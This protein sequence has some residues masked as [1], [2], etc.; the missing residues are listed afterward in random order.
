M[1][2]GTERVDNNPL[3][4]WATTW[5][6]TVSLL[7]CLVLVGETHAR[8]IDPNELEHL[9]A[10]HMVWTGAVPYRDFFEPVLGVRCG[11]QGAVA[12]TTGDDRLRDGHVVSDSAAGSMP[13]GPPRTARHAW[14]IV[15]CGDRRKNN[16]RFFTTDHFRRRRCQEII[17]EGSQHL[18]RNGA[19]TPAGV[20][21]SLLLF[22]G[23]ASCLST[24][25]STP[26][27]EL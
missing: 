6:L 25:R 9:H 20:R 10:S 2:Q 4:S 11:N 24:L 23:V 16:C 5:L 8:G 13:L 12:R 15:S 3:D 21:S 14:A 19:G 1:S 26:G 18:A 7:V 17:P 22:R 27:S